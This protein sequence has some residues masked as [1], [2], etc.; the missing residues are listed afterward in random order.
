MVKVSTSPERSFLVSFHADSD[1][2][3]SDLSR[4][5]TDLHRTH[6]GPGIVGVRREELREAMTEFARKL[7]KARAVGE[8]LLRIDELTSW[9]RFLGLQS[10]LMMFMSCFHVVFF[11]LG[12]TLD[13]LISSS[14]QKLGGSS[15]PPK[16]HQLGGAGWNA[17]WF[18]RCF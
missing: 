9:D 6:V 3:T 17:C 1:P 7:A 18:G 10:G 16:T 15:T 5:F 12:G 8:A 11:F 2:R 13:E 4:D 14:T